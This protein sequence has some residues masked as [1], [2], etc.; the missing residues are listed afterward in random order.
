M[1]IDNCVH[2]FSKLSQII[3]PAHMKRMR[4]AIKSPF[5]MSLFC[6]PG[7]GKQSILRT[8]NRSADLKGCYVLLHKKKP[9]YVGISRSV[10]Q[11]VM[12][13]V[14]GKTHFDASLAYRMTADKCPSKSHRSAA[15]SD[16]QFRKEFER[17]KKHLST[18]YIAFIEIDNDLELYLFEAFCALELKT[19]KWN[20]FRTH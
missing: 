7:S 13:H 20:T 15:M 4:Q 3:L 12:Q 19:S 5:K 17:V 9:I 11:R 1:P 14:R 2:S 10:L 6:Q 8:L 18:H 16:P